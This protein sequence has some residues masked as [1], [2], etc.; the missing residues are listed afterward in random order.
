M[1]LDRTTTTHEFTDECGDTH[2]WWHNVDEPW[3]DSYY[4]VCGECFHVYKTEQEL[5]DEYNRVT[6]EMNA[7]PD[8]DKFPA[9]GAK[10]PRDPI[11]PKTSGDDI[12]FC[13]FCMHDF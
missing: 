7:D 2:C 5:V 8:R 9:P 11:P 12:H 3:N 6:G 10:V 1:K 4:C 13:Q